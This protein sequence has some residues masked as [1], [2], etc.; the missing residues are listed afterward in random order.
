MDHMPPKLAVNSGYM[1]NLYIQSETVCGERRR[2]MRRRG[3]VVVL[4]TQYLRLH[5]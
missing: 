2:T 4:S 3:A 5:K 1:G